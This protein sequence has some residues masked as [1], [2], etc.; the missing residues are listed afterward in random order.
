MDWMHSI[1]L[2]D[3][4]YMY[5][6]GSSIHNPHREVVIARIFIHTSF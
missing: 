6:A 1:Q 3:A 2:I 4:S 5:H